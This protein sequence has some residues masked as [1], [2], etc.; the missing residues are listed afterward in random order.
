M[1]QPKSAPPKTKFNPAKAYTCYRCKKPINTYH[2]EQAA[3]GKVHVV[4]EGACP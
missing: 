4:H 3:D 1:R 2:I